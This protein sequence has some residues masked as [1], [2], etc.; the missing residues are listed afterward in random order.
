[1]LHEPETIFP[2]TSLSKYGRMAARLNKHVTSSGTCDRST[3]AT[4]MPCSWRCM[5]A[6]EVLL[7]RGKQ[8]N[9]VDHVMYVM[10][11]V[12]EPIAPF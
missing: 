7:R 10:M 11:H 6:V 8:C 1:M 12:L 3:T 9:K 4:L 2:F 5:G